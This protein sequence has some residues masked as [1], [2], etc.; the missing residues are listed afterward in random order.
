[1]TDSLT[2]NDTIARPLT[3]L[4]AAGAAHMVEISSKPITYREA[5]ASGMVRMAP[6]TLQLVMSG[7]GMKGDVL[8]T[9]RLAGIMG[10]KRTSELIPLCHP[11]CLESV[12]VGFEA[13]QPDQL[14]I[15]ARA[16]I[17]GRTG[18]EMEVLTAVAAAALTVYDMCKSADKKMIIAE[19][20]ID[21]KNGGRSGHYRRSHSAD[22]G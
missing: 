21:E 5:V 18:V 2:A 10:A 7:R 13:V 16:A 22:E 11:I 15:Q 17:T 1:M 19:I 14:R 12:S 8:A 4:D 20:Q 3:H 6:E 9:A